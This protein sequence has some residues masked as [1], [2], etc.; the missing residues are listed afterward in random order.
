MCYFSFSYPLLVLIVHVMLCYVMLFIVVGCCHIFTLFWCFYHC[1]IHV[2]LQICLFYFFWLLLL[3]SLQPSVVFRLNSSY[4]FLITLHTGLLFSISFALLTF[5][6]SVPLQFFFFF[7][8]Y[9]YR[10][11]YTYMYNCMSICQRH[12]D[13]HTR[14]STKF[15]MVLVSV[16]KSIALY[17]HF[18]AYT[19]LK[20]KPCLLP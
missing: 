7:F 1:H 11:M 3:S 20:L 18:D 17:L 19:C 2:A 9:T 10:C 14:V 4:L 15:G 16:P 8:S 12:R 13:E 5:L 6:F